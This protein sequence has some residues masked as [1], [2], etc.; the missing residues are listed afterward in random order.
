MK[1]W[2]NKRNY[3]IV[4]DRSQQ[5]PSWEHEGKSRLEVAGSRD[6]GK[7]LIAMG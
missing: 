1:S 5:K 7:L 4:E 3:D 2:I 6:M